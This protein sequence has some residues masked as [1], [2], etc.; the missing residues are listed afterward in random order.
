VLGALWLAL[1]VLMAWRLWQLLEG[2]H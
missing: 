2:Q 1:G